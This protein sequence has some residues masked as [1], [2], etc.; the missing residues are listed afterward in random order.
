MQL[1]AVE[2]AARGMC[3]QGV[4]PPPA[5]LVEMSSVERARSAPGPEGHS[6]DAKVLGAIVN[7]LLA[8]IRDGGSLSVDE[9]TQ[10]FDLLF[11]HDT[12]GYFWIALSTALH[13]RGETAEELEGICCSI[14][15]IV[16]SDREEAA[17]LDFNGTGR[18]P[19][20]TINVGT[21]ASIVAAACGLSVAKHGSGSVTGLLGSMDVA[22]RFGLARTWPEDRAG[23]VADLASSRVTFVHNF[24][25]SGRAHTRTG[26]LRTMRNEGLRISSPFH[27]VGGVPQVV[28]T[29]SRVFGVFDVSLHGRLAEV[30]ASRV[31]TFA[32][33]TAHDGLGDC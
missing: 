18:R 25:R 11:E 5:S 27:L 19:F 14:D 1:R 32:L 7:P 30:M 17:D 33:V 12:R 2:P 23:I 4:G 16:P 21:A 28:R 9:T 29:R 26:L 22:T 3:T 8:R 15:R 6:S 20:P 13:F 10:A 31:S 24:L